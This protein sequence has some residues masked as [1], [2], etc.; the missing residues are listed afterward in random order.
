M[1]LS[2]VGDPAPDD[3]PNNSAD[4]SDVMKCEFMAESLGPPPSKDAI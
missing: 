1:V 2:V 4:E 3:E